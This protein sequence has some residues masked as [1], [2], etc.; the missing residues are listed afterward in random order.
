MEI[1]REIELLKEKITLLEK[2]KDLQ[3]AIKA[4]ETQN[5]VSYIPWY[6]YP[7]YPSIPCPQPL[8]PSWTVI[9]QTQSM[10]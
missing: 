2:I 5:V 9:C 1:E 7:V 4:K 6:P 8:Y 3:D 10:S